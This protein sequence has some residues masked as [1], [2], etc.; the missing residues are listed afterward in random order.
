MQKR[1]TARRAG[2]YHSLVMLPDRLYPFKTEVRGQGVRGVRS[3]NA[4]FARY[5]RKYGAGS[6]G[7][8]LEAYRQLFHLAGS[9][10]F[11]IVAAYLSQSL[12]GSVNAIY[13]FLIAAVVLI[14]FQEF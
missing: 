13:A 8:K 6:Y 10:L 12:F 11:L 14:S 3:Y 9:I 2:L 1:H 5:Q 7:F 4:A